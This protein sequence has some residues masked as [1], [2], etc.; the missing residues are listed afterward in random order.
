MGM[1]GLKNDSLIKVNYYKSIYQKRIIELANGMLLMFG[2]IP[3]V[4][5]AVTDQEDEILLW[6]LFSI[7]FLFI[8][9]SLIFYP[10][11]NSKLRLDEIQI[12]LE[13]EK[14][15]SIS[16]EQIYLVTFEELKDGFGRMVTMTI[17]F[18]DNKQIILYF[19][20]FHIKS[21]KSIVNK[22]IIKYLLEK[23]IKFVWKNVK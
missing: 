7:L 23:N 12:T 4:I 14:S 1:F 3:L 21:P 6:V 20:R 15:I 18:N 19:N 22:R 2:S 13:N 9:A 11:S 16:I 5:Y 10:I 17:D 8:L